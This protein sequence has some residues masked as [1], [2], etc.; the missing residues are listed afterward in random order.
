MPKFDKIN[1]VVVENKNV[2]VLEICLD[3]TKVDKI[4]CHEIAIK[5]RF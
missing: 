5:I 3:P 1:K 2:S 4:C